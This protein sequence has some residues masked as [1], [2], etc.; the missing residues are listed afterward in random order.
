M[1]FYF[2]FVPYTVSGFDKNTAESK[3]LVSMHNQQISVSPAGEIRRLAL[4]SATGSLIGTSNSQ[5]LSVSGNEKGVYILKIETINQLP[6]L[7]KLIIN[8]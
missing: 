3:F 5:T 2:D 6:V 8:Q 1:N 7:K 4:Y